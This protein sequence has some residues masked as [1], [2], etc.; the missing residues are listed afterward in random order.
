MSP[1]DPR[2]SRYLASSESYSSR[3]WDGIDISPICSWAMIETNIL[4]QCCPNDVC[5]VRK[6]RHHWSIIETRGGDSLQPPL[7]QFTGSQ[8]LS[9]ALT[10]S[11]VETALRQPLYSKEFT[12]ALSETRWSQ[13]GGIREL[14]LIQHLDSTETAPRMARCAYWL[15]TYY[16]GS[17][18][19]NGSC[20]VRSRLY[21]H[22][23]VNTD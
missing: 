2:R 3:V 22:P 16:S 18:H 7:R 1:P 17:A 23:P 12:Q 20:H 5:F 6:S 21:P 15:P 11:N 10:A 14:A 8:W 13:R 9:P 4:S 19:H